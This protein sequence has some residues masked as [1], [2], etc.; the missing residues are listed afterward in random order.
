MRKN[1]KEVSRGSLKTGSAPILSIVTSRDHSLIRM[2][3]SV[4]NYLKE[5]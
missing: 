4:S 5:R 2:D 3:M 1:N